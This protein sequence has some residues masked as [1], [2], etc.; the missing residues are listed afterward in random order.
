MKQG[1][2]VGYYV[3]KDMPQ[4]YIFKVQTIDKTVAQKVVSKWCAYNKKNWGASKCSRLF[5]CKD[6]SKNLDRCY[7]KYGFMCVCYPL[8]W[9][10]LGGAY[11]VW[12]TGNFKGA[13]V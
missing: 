9:D 4:V 2:M 11:R 13:I 10:R 8:S 5:V 6:T 1:Y 7:D 12:E 3:G